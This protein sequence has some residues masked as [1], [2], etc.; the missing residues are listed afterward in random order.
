MEPGG[1]GGKALG[2]DLSPYEFHGRIP[3]RQA[4]PLGMQHVLAMF[5]G[6]I[7]PMILVAQAAE[8][9][10]YHA[11]LLIQC[12]VLGAG[13]ATLIQ[14]FPIRLG[15]IRIG[16]GLPVMM[17]LTYTF[18]PICLAVATNGELGLPVLFGAQLVAALSSVFVAFVLPYIR[19][20][21]PPI[22]TGTI[23]VS[24]GISCFSIAAYNLAGGQGA[25]DLGQPHNWIIGAVVI[26]V[27]VGCTSFGKGMVNAAA[28]LIGIVAGY[29]IAAVVTV[30]GIVPGIDFSRIA[31]AKWFAI[32]QPLAFGGTY[33]T[34]NGRMK[35]P[36]PVAMR[37]APTITVG[38]G[39]D[40]LRVICNGTQYV[41]TG[42]GGVQAKA[43]GV[44]CQVT[45][46][47]LPSAHAA[48]LMFATEDVME[49]S[50]E[51]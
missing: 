14:A 49:L 43:D 5:V 6:N 45:A 41:G 40:N 21:F 19:K 39:V 12:C 30:A 18:L 7:V 22:V 4:I 32:P 8:M 28:V 27:I 34:G 47:E 29:V 46:A 20:F 33:G 11:T 2:I 3:L 38:K 1:N 23:I 42:I 31:A 25:P 26:L 10:S 50:A 15:K 51:L 37:I 16:S 44:L 17:G 24:I 9:D 13:V 35:T 36:T 48:T